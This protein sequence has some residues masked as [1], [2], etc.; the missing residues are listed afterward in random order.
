MKKPW[1]MGLL[2]IIPGLGFFLLGRIRQGFFLWLLVGGLVAI[3]LFSS[4]ENLSVTVYTL[5]FIAWI[6]QGIFAILFARSQART[7]AGLDLL[8]REVSIAPPQPDASRGKKHLHKARVS[9]LDLLE[10]GEDLKAAVIMARPG[11]CAFESLH[12]DVS[13]DEGNILRQT[14]V[15]PTGEPNMHVCLA[16]DVTQI[17]QASN[18]NLSP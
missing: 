3:G 9:V 13:T 1:V 4:G 11:L 15:V 10:Q 5:A 6:T 18:E 17:K 7:E 8:V 2:S 16:P 14:V 12:L